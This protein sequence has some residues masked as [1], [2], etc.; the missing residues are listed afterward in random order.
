MSL[1]GPRPEQ[2][3]LFDQLCQE[4]PQFELRQLVRPGITGWAQVVQGYADDEQSSRV[5]LSHDLY[6]IKHF[7]PTLDLLIITRTLT[8]ILTGFGSR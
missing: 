5:K 4:I 1:I 3:N 6:Y 2:K 7:G 8:T